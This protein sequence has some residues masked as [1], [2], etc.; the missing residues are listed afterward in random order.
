MVTILP[1]LM[2]VVYLMVII[3]PA[4][5]NVVYPMGTILPVRIVPEFPTVMLT[6]IIAEPVIMTA[7]TTVYKTVPEPGVV[8][9]Q[10]T[11]VVSVAV[12]I[13]PVRIVPVFPMVMPMKITVEPVIMTAPMTV[14]RTVAELGVVTS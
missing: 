10:M 5:M 4:R 2:N 13:H 6:K 11:T 8:I 9:S 12:I 7:L 1:V 3:L 14:Y